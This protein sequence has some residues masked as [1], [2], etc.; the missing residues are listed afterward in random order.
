[1][2]TIQQRKWPILELV[3]V[4]ICGMGLCFALGFV[5]VSYSEDRVAKEKQELLAR[6]DE[7]KIALAA[8]KIPEEQIPGL[9]CVHKSALVS[10]TTHMHFII[11]SF[12]VLLSLLIASVGL[13][14]VLWAKLRDFTHAGKA[15]VDAPVTA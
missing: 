7:M 15:R 14:I 10:E 13:T 6:M 5:G 2:T 11:L 1:M 3:G 8:A 9:L 4:A 12:F